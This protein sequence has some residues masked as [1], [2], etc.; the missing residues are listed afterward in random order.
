MP[1]YFAIV[2]AAGSGSRFGAEK[3]KRYLSLFGR[4]MIFHTLA[5]LVACPTIER[6]WVVPPLRT[7]IGINTTGANLGRSLKQCV[8]AAKPVRQV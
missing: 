3:P 8:V 1:R 5:A 2:P 7:I 4:P 6:V